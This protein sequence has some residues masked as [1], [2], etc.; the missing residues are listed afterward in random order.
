MRPF[1]LKWSIDLMVPSSGTRAQ[2]QSELCILS[3]LNLRLLEAPSHIGLQ[4]GLKWWLCVTWHNTHWQE[5]QHGY[6]AIIKHYQ[7]ESRLMLKSHHQNV[8]K[9]MWKNGQ[10]FSRNYDK[11]QIFW[12]YSFVPNCRHK[13]VNGLLSSG[14]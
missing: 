11:F 7:M 9:I 5:L 12:Y 1:S 8:E 3:K 6:L 10:Y 2:C 14:E 13:E 4:N